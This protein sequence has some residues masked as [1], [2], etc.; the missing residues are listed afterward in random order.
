VEAANGAGRRR[1]RHRGGVA[2]PLLANLYLHWFDAL[3]HGPP[4]AGTKGRCQ[5]GCATADDFVALGENGWDRKPSSFI[6]S[7]L[8]RKFQLEI[9]R[10][11]T[12]VVDLREEG[13]S[14]NFLGYTFS[15]RPRP[16]KDAIGNT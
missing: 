11:K 4:R 14:L 3:F 8:E 9:N 12:R 6:E 1:E 2:S 15:V 10:E 13:A 5:V 7:R 16:G